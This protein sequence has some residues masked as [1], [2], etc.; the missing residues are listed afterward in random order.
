MNAE[1]IQDILLS[2]NFTGR[3][4]PAHVVETHIS[5]I[6]LTPDFAF[7]IKK[8]VK[9]DFLDFSTF[10]NRRFYCG[11]EFRLNR[12]LAPEMYLGV[13]PVG[14]IDGRPAIGA[15][16]PPLLDYAV[17]MRRMDELSQMNILLAKN[18]VTETHME[19]LARQ[20]AGFHRRVSIRPPN[21]YAPGDY[22]KDFE[23]LY[24]EEKDAIK[25]LGPEAR[26]QFDAWRLQIPAFLDAHAHRMQT[27]FEEGY[28]VEGHGDLHTRNIFLPDLPVVFDCIEFNPNFRR[29][30]VLND[31]SFLC[32]DLEALGHPELGFHFMENYRRIWEVAPKL[33]DEQL[34]LFYKAYRSNVRL[35]VYLLELRQHQNAAL[36]E[37]VRLYWRLLKNYCNLL[38]ADVS[39]NAA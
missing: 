37:S 17:W 38:Q 36:L 4:E 34:F 9:F 12:R 2:G 27:R 7:K 35:K 13:L 25:W 8:P 5:W 31:L 20:L 23:D 32:M 14:T 22:L 15:L 28:W 10:E 11:E 29:I 33:E 19:I 16:T 18:L 39:Q 26:V 21:V 1:Q 30:D 6:I 24:H 3:K